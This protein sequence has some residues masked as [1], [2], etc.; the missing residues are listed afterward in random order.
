MN[1]F[2]LERHY[3]NLL[4][5]VTPDG[6]ALVVD[7]HEMPRKTSPKWFSFSQKLTDH[8]T[9]N[10]IVSLMV[11][12]S[13][14]GEHTQWSLYGIGQMDDRFWRRCKSFGLIFMIQSPM[15]STRHFMPPMQVSSHRL[16]P[17]CQDLIQHL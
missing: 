16:G 5:P 4:P 7:R 15:I 3:H 8:P 13:D 6:L 2:H 12:H 1:K 11:S 17:R 14:D 10:Q 9:T